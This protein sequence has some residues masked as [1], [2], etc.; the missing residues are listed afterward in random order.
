MRPRSARG[1]GMKT[2]NIPMRP[3]SANRGLEPKFKAWEAW[4]RKKSACGRGVLLQPRWACMCEKRPGKEILYSDILIW[5][6][7]WAHGKDAK[8]GA[9]CNTLQHTVATRNCCTW[10]HGGRC[11]VESSIIQ[12]HTASH[13]IAL[14]HTATPCNTL[15]YLCHTWAH[16]EGRRSVSSML[17][18]H[19]AT[20]FTT[21]QHPATP[22]N[23]L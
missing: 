19:T 7:N 6:F 14:Q 9:A 2:Q 18:G 21:L 23:T 4:M 16:G 1:W 11:W 12:D 10:A 17:Q 20:P 5:E 13:C 22:Y 3:V 15:Q 8:L